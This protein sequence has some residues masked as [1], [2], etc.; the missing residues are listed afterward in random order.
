MSFKCV[1]TLI[2]DICGTELVS[3]GK[4]MHDCASRL[5]FEKY[6]CKRKNWKVIYNKYHVCKRCVECFGIQ[7][8]RKKFK[9]RL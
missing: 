7:Y 2:C 5:R 9:E 4:S 1:T 8:L 3:S 6:I